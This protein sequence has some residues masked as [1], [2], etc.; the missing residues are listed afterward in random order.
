[1]IGPDEYHDHVDNNVYTNRMAQWHLQTA[2]FLLGWL[3]ERYPEKAHVLRQQLDLNEAVLDHWRDVIEH[4]IIP[5]DPATGLM[6]QFEG[7]FDLDY[8]DPADIRA[9]T[10]SMQ[11][12][13]GIEGANAAQVIK[14]ADAIMLL[15]LLRDEYDRKTWQKNWDTYMPI[16]DHQYGSSL[17]PSF[18]A[19]AACEMNRPDEGYEHFMLAARADLYDVR[20]NAGDGIHAASAGGLWQAAV[21]GFAGLRMTGDGLAARPR[22]P[23]HWRRLRFCVR[24]CGHI[25]RVEVTPDGEAH[26]SAANESL[27]NRIAGA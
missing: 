25:Y 9:T 16:T 12:V 23:G 22:L 19:W 6:V 18:H 3:E 2:M 13:L 20:G 26:I 8:V 4:V 21:F 1:V 7:F 17:G 11:V 27:E 24:Y 14:Q 5:H 10:R 15:C